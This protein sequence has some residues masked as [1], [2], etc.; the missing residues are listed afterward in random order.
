MK[1]SAESIVKLST[2]TK[3]PDYSAHAERNCIDC[4]FQQHIRG[5]EIKVLITG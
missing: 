5:H 3:W 2:R 1:L 4:Q